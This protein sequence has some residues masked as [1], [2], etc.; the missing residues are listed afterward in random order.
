MPLFG[1]PKKEEQQY[2]DRMMPPYPDQGQQAYQQPLDM[3]N[4]GY[5]P[6]QIYEQQAMPQQQMPMPQP[7]PSFDSQRIE[8]VAEAII[9]EKWNDLLKDINKMV[10]WKE[11]TESRL[12]K[13]E[14]DIEN[15]KSNF[16]ALHKGIL[17]KITEYDQ[18]LVEVGTEIK[19]ME[20]VFQK[21]LPTFTENVSKL[22]RFT[23]N[24]PDATIKKK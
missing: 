14:Q 8:E 19:A 13:I 11:K 18:N 15:L 22:E 1:K 16:D 17:G 20:K 10:E 12:V 4:Q 3:Q 6:Q 5:P 21:I 23:R 9:D 7:E 2:S 24:I